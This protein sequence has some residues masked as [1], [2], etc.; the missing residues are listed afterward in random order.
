VP[1]AA[2]AVAANAALR[3]HISPACPLSLAIDIFRD[4]FQDVTS[5]K[6]TPL[7]ARY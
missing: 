5:S 7:L 6:Q 4:A 1:R 2:S 3:R